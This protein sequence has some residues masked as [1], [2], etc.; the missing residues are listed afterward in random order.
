MTLLYTIRLL[1][2]QSTI[3]RSTLTKFYSQLIASL[4]CHSVGIQCELIDLGIKIQEDIES[5]ALMDIHLRAILANLESRTQPGGHSACVMRA[6]LDI[7]YL[8]IRECLGLC[9]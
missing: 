4:P 5:K 7:L 8:R 1:L 6:N 2:Q 9:L 3:N